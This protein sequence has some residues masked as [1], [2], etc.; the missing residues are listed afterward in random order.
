MRWACALLLSL[1]AP[2]AAAEVTSL[3]IT[4]KRAFGTFKPG[5]F[6]LWEGKIHGDLS[7][8]EAIPGMDKATRNARGRVEYS[9]RI[10]L[11]FPVDPARGNGTLVVDIPNRGR[12][13]AQALFNSPRD[14]PF[15]SGTFEQGNGF[16]Q[17]HG[18]SVAEIHWELG[19][20]AQLPSFTDEAGK[21]LFVEGA[22]FAIVRDAVQFLRNPR[23]D[24]QVSAN[25]LRG[26]VQR[27]IGTGKSQS[28]RFLKTF[29]L[30]GFNKSGDRLVFDGMQILTSAGM[31]S[32]MRTSA[33]PESSANGIPLFDD[34]EMRGYTEDPLA[35][36][37]LMQRVIGRGETPP[38]ML[39]MNATTDY[40]SIRSSL[41]RTGPT[42]TA[43]LPLPP[44]V[45][46]Y[47][48]A[49]APHAITPNAPSCAMKPGVL[50][51]SPV[52]RA[53]LLHLDAWVARGTEPPATRL[54]PL[55]VATPEAALRAPAYWPGAVIQVPKRDADG[56]ALGGIRL[57]DIEAPLGTHVGL[58]T[59]R[60]RGCMLVGGY[61]PFAATM[62]ER[63]AAGDARLSVAERYRTRDDY[64]NRVR[65]AA[66]KLDSD[67]FL[68][69][70][71]AAVII[72]AAASSRA[73]AKR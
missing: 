66:R 28:G 41:V 62:A 61:Q 55:E 45:R 56:N 6:A 5:D 38:R 13:Y 29:L 73:F 64:V 67:G 22:G 19:Q 10:V 70:D 58:N 35:I 21:P 63:E 25:P 52:M 65:N 26:S 3:E 15:Q 1:W 69:P 60:T 59:T 71:D 47:D 49:G 23:S 40:Y 57:P 36:A 68:L 72:Q 2:I 17:D 8:Q 44:N 18:F 54:M 9:A 43:D 20:G 51:F 16:L 50:E 48:I 33:G 24:A 46:M 27:V 31:L 7:P 39:V 37:E 4:T 34:V 12:A 42:G 14:E 53:L 11:I 30:G 32:L